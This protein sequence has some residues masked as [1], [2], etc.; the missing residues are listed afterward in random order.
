MEHR[1]WLTAIVI[2][3]KMLSLYRLCHHLVCSY[4]LLPPIIKEEKREQIDRRRAE[5]SMS[6]APRDLAT[7]KHALELGLILA[8]LILGTIMLVA[9]GS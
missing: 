3:R 1:G 2:H 6:T 4:P 8:T 5:M 9:A 7:I